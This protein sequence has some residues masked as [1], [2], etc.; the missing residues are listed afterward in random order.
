MKPDHDF[1][2]TIRGERGEEWK[3]VIGTDTVPVVS[4]IPIRANLPGLGE[5]SAFL[6]AIDQLEPE[7]FQAIVRH[8]SMKFGIALRE[9]ETTI[10]AEGIPILD[11]D[12]T[13]VVLNPQKWF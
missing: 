12:C 7:T 5:Q 3:Q 6:L 13:L 1:F 8:L 2:V 4:P 11:H 9:I 10:R